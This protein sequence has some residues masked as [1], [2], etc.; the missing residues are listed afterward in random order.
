[1]KYSENDGGKQAQL[2]MRVEEDRRTRTHLPM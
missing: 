2:E 1:M